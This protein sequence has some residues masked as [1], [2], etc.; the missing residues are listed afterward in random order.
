MNFELETLHSIYV[1]LCGVWSTFLYFFHLLALKLFIILMVYG[2]L[3]QCRKMGLI[4]YI[5]IKIPVRGILLF[6]SRLF[7]HGNFGFF[8]YYYSSSP[9]V[10]VSC[11]SSETAGP[12]FQKISDMMHLLLGQLLW[13]LKF[14]SASWIM[15]QINFRVFRK[16]FISQRI[17]DEPAISLYQMK[18]LE[19]LYRVYYYC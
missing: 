13:S 16:T 15:I 18:A 11:N 1:F 10:W 2:T 19:H 12:I 17:L 5:I 14:W 7:F 3:S 4:K 9:H 6:L 8:S